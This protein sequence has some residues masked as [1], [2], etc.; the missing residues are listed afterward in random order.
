MCTIHV[1]DFS[2]HSLLLHLGSDGAKYIFSS[3]YVPS[4]Q[5]NN[6]QIRWKGPHVTQKTILNQGFEGTVIEMTRCP[7]NAYSL[8]LSQTEHHAAIVLPSAQTS[9]R[10][11]RRQ[12]Y[13][14]RKWFKASSQHLWKELI[15]LKV[16]TSSL[17]CLFSAW[18]SEV[19]VG[20]LIVIWCP[21]VHLLGIGDQKSRSHIILRSCLGIPGLGP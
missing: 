4:L 13:K 11:G 5:K 8:D 20:S 19:M 14:W 1:C 17:L 18:N 16:N 6:I 2:L 15:Q 21:C 7:F 12:K 10:M 3:W 9:V